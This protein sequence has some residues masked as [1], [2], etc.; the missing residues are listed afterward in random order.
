MHLITTSVSD[1]YRVLKIGDEYLTFT[2]AKEYTIRYTYN[3][4]KDTGKDYDEFYFN[5]IGDQWDTAIGNVT[6]TVTMPR[7]FDTGKLGFS[8]GA[9][10]STDSAGIT[11]Q[12]NG[13]VI[14][15]QL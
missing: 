2:G 1:G 3:I 13:N 11:W 7:E 12:V 5:L 8:R 15:R 14:N 10:G 9:T 4:G 6:F